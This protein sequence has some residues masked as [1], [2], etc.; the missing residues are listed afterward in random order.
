MQLPNLS[1]VGIPVSCAACTQLS[2]AVPAGLVSWYIALGYDSHAAVLVGA[3][4]W[5]VIVNINTLKIIKLGQLQ[6]N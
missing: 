5:L 1:Q 4:F 3:L 2:T 6:L